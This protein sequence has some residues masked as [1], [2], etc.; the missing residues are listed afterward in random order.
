[1]RAVRYHGPRQPFRLEAVSIP[2]PG[3][4]EVR[5]RIA[6][7]GLCRTELHLR[8]GLLDLGRRGFTVGHEIAGTV[9]ALGAGADPVLLGRPVAVYYYEG[10]GACP[11][12]T[13]G[14]P[15]LCVAPRRQPGFT[16]DGGLAEWIAVPAA[17]CVPLP[18]HLSLPAAAPL[19]CAGSTA[20]HACRLAALRAG[21]RVVVHG[22]GGVGFAL[23]Q[24]ARVAGA[25]VTALAR[26]PAQLALCRE[27]G[28]EHVVDLSAS[29]D[30]VS[31]AAGHA[32]AAGADVVFELA[33]TSDTMARSVA[34]LGRKG[35]L[36]LIGY[37]ADDFRVH[38]IPL[39]VREARVIGSVGATPDDLREAVRLAAAGSLRIPLDRELPLDRFADGLAALERGGLSGRIV[40]RP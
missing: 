19:G 18:P 17:N 21:E 16:D 34:M 15:N 23:I 22:A 40:L 20:V 1:M 6:A 7:C 4:G 10:C 35:R 14:E 26:D 31:D 30:P 25:R 24:V 33:G 9:D 37:T 29:A 13:D 27:L 39:I 28:A 32:G 38:P 8:D 12:C 36:V 3:A 5:V 11:P 2:E